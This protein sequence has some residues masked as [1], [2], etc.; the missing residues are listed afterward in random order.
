VARP[1]I[2]VTCGASTAPLVAGLV[3]RWAVVLPHAD[4]AERLRALGAEAMAW[5]ALIDPAALR[6]LPARAAGMAADWRGALARRADDLFR[7]G[8]RRQ[9]ALGPAL[10]ALLRARLPEHLLAVE[11]ARSLARTGRLRAAVTHDD[12]TGL[13][14]A[15]VEALRPLGVPT[16]H[17]PHGVYGDE[18]VVGADV[19]GAAHAD[20]VAVGGPAQRDWFLRHGVPPERLV[21]TGNPAWDALAPPP[22]PRPSLDLPPGPVVTVAGSW[23]GG[24]SAYRAFTRHDQDR[25]MRAC[26]A[27]VGRLQ[28]RDPALR[29]VV[30]V[31]PSAPAG[32]EARLAA[33]AAESG[34]RTDL[35]ARDRRA[36][37][38][39]ASDALLTLPSTIAIEAILAGT[40]V[41]AADVR[42]AGDAVLS[43]PAEPEALAAAL[44][45]AVDGWRASPEFARR[46]RDF[47]ARYNGPSDGRAGERVIALVERL[48]GLRDAG[49]PAAGGRA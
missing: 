20:V 42:Y 16:V 41:V 38:L 24:N 32:E 25:R 34:A 1:L 9:P 33:L 46:R 4:R 40:P 28:A 5:D 49:R 19:H 7:F 31:H 39:A 12:V 26:L 48:A 8:G 14:R 35:V 15:F 18:T 17:V 23:I 47:L 2:F 29:L 45:H 13:V 3:E 30:K 43:A 10:D 6:D 11:A 37:I 44:V 21:V 36:E 22:G 27:A